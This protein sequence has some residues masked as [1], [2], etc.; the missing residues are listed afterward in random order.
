ML[1][2]MALTSC[3]H[4]TLQAM[5]LPAAHDAEISASALL[6]FQDIW[7]ARH[8]PDDTRSGWLQGARYSV[9]YFVNPKLNYI[10]EGPEK[11]FSPVTGFD[12][13]SKTGNAYAARKNGAAQVPISLSKSVSL[14]VAS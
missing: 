8:T 13:L 2:N 5:Q 4:S 9:P 6:I 10:I 12:L 11:R 14:Q 7:Q 3:A 1:H